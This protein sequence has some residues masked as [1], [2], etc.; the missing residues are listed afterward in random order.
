MTQ[1]FYLLSKVMMPKT[2]ACFLVGRSIV[3]GKTIDNGSLLKRAA[4]ANGFRQVA[5]VERRINQTR[6]AFNPALSKIS[7][8]SIILFMAGSGN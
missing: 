1:V 8:E 3:H 5:K 6:R 4:E 2:L 7:Q